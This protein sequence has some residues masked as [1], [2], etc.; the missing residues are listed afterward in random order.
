MTVVQFVQSMSVETIALLLGF[1]VLLLIIVTLHT[2]NLRWVRS[3]ATREETS[4][5]KARMEKL[6]DAVERLSRSRSQS[7]AL[8]NRPLNK[9]SKRVPAIRSAAPKTAARRAR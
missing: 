3:M 4:A 7:A 9:G 8:R 2:R 5:T 6:L 1:T